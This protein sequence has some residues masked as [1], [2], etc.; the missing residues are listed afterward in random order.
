MHI[1]GRRIALD[2]RRKLGVGEEIHDLEFWGQLQKK[3]TTMGGVIILI[4][5]PGPVLLRPATWAASTSG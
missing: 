2:F 3:G 5:I 1:F 4:A